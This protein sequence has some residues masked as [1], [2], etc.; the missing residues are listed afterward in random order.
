MSGRPS[1][2]EFL[3]QTGFGIGALALGAARVH[4]RVAGGS[5]FA[6]AHQAR[7]DLGEAAAVLR[8]LGEGGAGIVYKANQEPLERVVAIKVLRAEL[9]PTGLLRRFE[10][11]AA[12][13]AR[14]EH[15]GIARIYDAGADEG[16][17]YFAMELIDGSP[18]G[19]WALAN[20]PDSAA[21]RDLVN[22]SS[23]T[24]AARQSGSGLS[25]M[26]MSK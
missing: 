5:G 25:W 17:P 10:H 16:Q 1:R 3:G 8:V 19:H 20:D 24:A 4:R 23:A 14:L 6:L 11:E 18:L 12:V 22:A 7:T 2:R 26:M 15:P 13:L 21:Q 9:A